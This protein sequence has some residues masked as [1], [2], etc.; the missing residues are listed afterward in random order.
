MELNESVSGRV[1]W[2]ADFDMEINMWHCGGGSALGFNTY[3]R[4]GSSL[5][6]R[7]V[8]YSLNKSLS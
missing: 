5:G 6:Q 4:E 8:G 3:G 1:P 7:E 2:A